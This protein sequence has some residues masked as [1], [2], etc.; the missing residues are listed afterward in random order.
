MNS[1]GSNAERVTNSPYA[2]YVPRWSTDGTMIAFNSGPFEEWEVY[3]INSDETNLK[4]VTNSPGNI[5]AINPVWKPQ[6]I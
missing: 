4:Q 5:T 6:K 3:I 2:D 1:D